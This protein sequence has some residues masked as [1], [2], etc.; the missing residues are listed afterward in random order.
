MF[1]IVIFWYFLQF[2]QEISQVWWIFIVTEV[3]N[4]KSLE[5]VWVIN[6]ENKIVTFLTLKVSNQTFDK[7]C[8][9]YYWGFNILMQYSFSFHISWTNFS[10]L[11]L[12]CII[13]KNTA[14]LMSLYLLENKFLTNNILFL[15]ISSQIL[16]YH[17]FNSH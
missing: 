5:T 11:C 9:I 13:F 2:R 10:L 3:V 1:L 17:G 15:I 4:I 7:T 16:F 6:V 8:L 14:H 12:F